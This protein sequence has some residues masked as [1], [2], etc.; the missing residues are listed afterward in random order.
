MNILYITH[1]ADLGGASRALLGIIDELSKRHNIYVL[2]AYNKGSMSEELKKRKC[3]V[4][5]GDVQWW[6]YPKKNLS[7]MRIVKNRL[8]VLWHFYLSMRKSLK[9]VLDELKKY[10]IDIVHSNTI[11]V[12]AGAVISAKLKVPHIWHL[13]EFVEEDFSYEFSLSRYISMLIVRKYAAYCIAVS[14]SVRRKYQRLGITRIRVIYDGVCE[15]EEKDISKKEWNGKESFN[16]LLAGTI[17]EGKG[18]KEAVLAMKEVV[19]RGYTECKLYLAGNGETENLKEFIKKQ[20]VEKYVCVLGYVDNINEL[21]KNMDV[22]LMCSS[23]EAFGLVT[24]ESMKAGVPVIGAATGGTLELINNG[25]NGM[26][27]HKGNYLELAD[28]IEKLYKNP[29]MLKKMKMQAVKIMN[30]KFTQENNAK[31]IERM[32]NRI[33]S[34]KG[35]G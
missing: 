30:G 14:K 12:Y 22:S 9:P 6:V 26:L 16:L 31:A 25:K 32:Y 29:E 27:Y 18:Q 23:A 35:N 15:I 28:C 13:R 21:R 2:T 33:I 20:K 17:S 11:A 5:I 7:K 19:R 8:Y 4:I 1:E 24:V 10:H 3:T 34:R